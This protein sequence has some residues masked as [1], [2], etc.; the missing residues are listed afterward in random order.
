MT[1]LLRV[2]K[3]EARTPKFETNLNDQNLKTPNEVVEIPLLYF[4]TKVCFGFRYSNF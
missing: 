2:S 1:P 4:D 3:S